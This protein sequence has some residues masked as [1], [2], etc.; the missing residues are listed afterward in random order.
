MTL[1]YRHRTQTHV[2]A[3]QVKGQRNIS[4]SSSELGLSSAPQPMV[5]LSELGEF[6]SLA[7]PQPI[8]RKDLQ[9]V[10]YV[11]AELNGRTPAEVIADV[12]ADKDVT[13]LPS[14]LAAA[15]FC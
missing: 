6:N 13:E 11:M 1:P 15:Y 12:S 10:I 2:G 14:T 4:Q 8:V 9:R 3:L 5:A 7:R